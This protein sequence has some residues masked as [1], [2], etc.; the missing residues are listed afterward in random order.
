M[1]KATEAR[2]DVVYNL[3]LNEDEAAVVM[4]CLYAI[5]WHEGDGEQAERIYG[6]LS[7]AGADEEGRFFVNRGDEQNILRRE[8]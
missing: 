8:K 5:A 2:R 1:A 3:E 7:D 4:A 6:A